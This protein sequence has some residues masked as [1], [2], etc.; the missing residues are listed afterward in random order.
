MS[1]YLQWLHN[2]QL[3]QGF[4]PANGFTPGQLVFPVAFPGQFSDPLSVF[5]STTAM[6]SQTFETLKNVQ[7]YLEGDD[8]DIE[9]VQQNWPY[10]GLGYS[11]R[12]KDLEGGLEI[13]FDGGRSYTRFSV[14]QG[15]RSDPNSWI[16]VPAVSIGYGAS[17]GVLTAFD[18]A[19]FLVR[20]VVP[21]HAKD[22]R[23]FNLRLEV[24][25]DVF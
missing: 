9:V 6:Q 2:N 14:D 25:C 20:M 12:R 7:L 11:P 1:F 5:L 15:Y 21:P 13:S 24:S 23:L 19:S 4:D 22:T 10:L 3:V 8:E 18:R 17:D 16:T